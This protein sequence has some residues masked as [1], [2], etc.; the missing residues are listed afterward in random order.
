MKARVIH[1]L[2]QYNV[3]AIK[4]LFLRICKR[5][6]FLDL[7]MR[8]LIGNEKVVE[9]VSLILQSLPLSGSSVKTAQEHSPLVLYLDKTRQNF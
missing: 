9:T 2:L 5:D 6:T 4:C 1:H 3:S 8:S 7:A